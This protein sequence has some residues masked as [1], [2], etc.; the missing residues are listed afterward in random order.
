MIGGFQDKGISE[1]AR[2]AWASVVA[3]LDANANWTAGQT[4]EINA[5]QTQVVAGTNYFYHVTSNGGHKKSVKVFVPL[6][7]TGSPAE[8]SGVADGHVDIS[9][10]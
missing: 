5:V 2:A 3:G 9:A 8:V 10:L 6:P 7:H 1:E 4:W